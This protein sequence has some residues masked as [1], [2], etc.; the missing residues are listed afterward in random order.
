MSRNPPADIIVKGGGSGDGIAAL[1]HGIVD[2]AMTSR[3]L[4]SRERD[5]A[6]SKGIE[7]YEFE[8]A[9]DGIAVVVNRA[10]LVA[11]LDLN[12]LR[13]LFAG[14]IRNWRELGGAKAQVLVFT[15]AAGSGTASVF[16]E[17]VLGGNP[18]AASA[19]YLP[20]NE[21]IVAEV[22]ARPAA[23]GYTGLGALKAAGNRIKVVAL[24]TA[25]QAVPVAPSAAAI[26]SRKYPLTRT[27]VL[28][29]A[30]ELSGTVK[31]FLEFCSSPSGQALFHSAGYVGIN[32]RPMTS[33]PGSDR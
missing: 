32:P 18:Y 14:S 27:L 9:L 2:V 7:I 8:L 25:A 31:A 22:A 13:N 15:R 17:R 26:R 29:A 20:T 10:N 21:A 33:L 1:L 24:R 19:Q 23:I 28:H 5:Y 3:K 11:A 6:V 16:G 4:S 12:Q 30:G